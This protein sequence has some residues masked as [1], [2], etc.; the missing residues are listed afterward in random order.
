LV[1]RVDEI[2]FKEL[3]ANPRQQRLVDPEEFAGKARKY[4]Y[5]GA[6]LLP[7][8]VRVFREYGIVVGNMDPVEVAARIRDR[9]GPVRDRLIAALENWMLL[10]AGNAAPRPEV[11]WLWA[12]VQGADTDSWRRQLRQAWIERNG[13]AFQKLLVDNPE[14][15]KQQS[16]STLV[17]L[18]RVLR[19]FELPDLAV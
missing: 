4:F 8:Y 5:S 18:A 13:R 12:V 1:A 7:E 11:K 2:R 9:S 6:E 10:A 16:P 15:V 14:F 3:A 17:L 19:S